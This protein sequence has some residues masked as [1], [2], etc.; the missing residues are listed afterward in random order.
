MS[1][2]YN[3]E[4]ME[5]EKV[6]PID[7]LEG[8]TEFQI[9]D[10]DNNLYKKGDILYKYTF[11]NAGITTDKV[12]ITTID[13]LDKIKATNYKEYKYN[14]SEKWSTISPSTLLRAAA[15]VDDFKT[16]VELNGRPSFEYK[17]V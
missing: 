8:K 7:L 3:V 10:Y 12:M 2:F 13:Y 6:D 16:I 14:N 9:V 11:T 17:V 15:C 5:I 1:E 4:N